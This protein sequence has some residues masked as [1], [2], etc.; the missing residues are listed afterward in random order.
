MALLDDVPVPAA[1]LA[2]DPAPPVP[3]P[4]PAPALAPPPAPPAPPP[5]PPPWARAAAVEKA[6]Q[7]KATRRDLRIM[8]YLPG[9]LDNPGSCRV[10]PRVCDCAGLLRPR[11]Q[12]AE[13][14]SFRRF[15]RSSMMAERPRQ[16]L[17]ERGRRRR[18]KQ[19]RTLPWSLLAPQPRRGCRIV[20]AAWWLQGGFNMPFE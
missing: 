10:V 6:A 17:Q 13:A 15:A 11:S 8:D 2:A 16:T 3:V 7:V 4:A 20:A 14:I 12:D 9:L 5:P 18:Q 19:L 1:E